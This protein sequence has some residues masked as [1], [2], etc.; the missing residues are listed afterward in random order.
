MEVAEN[1]YTLYFQDTRGLE[2]ENWATSVHLCPPA[3]LCGCQFHCCLLHNKPNET[4]QADHRLLVHG[5]SQRGSPFQPE[6]AVLGG[7]DL[8]DQPPQDSLV[9]LAILLLP[10]ELSLIGRLGGVDAAGHQHLLGHVGFRAAFVVDPIRELP[11]VGRIVLVALCSKV[12]VQLSALLDEGSWAVLSHLGFG[13][14]AAAGQ[15]LPV[16]L[17]PMLYAP[18][19]NRGEVAS[20]QQAEDGQPPCTQTVLHGGRI[21]K[22]KAELSLSLLRCPPALQQVTDFKGILIS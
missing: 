9:E 19:L 10:G 6:I 5:D 12:D 22:G 20:K 17:E 7:T 3:H 1:R 2:S 16:P 11:V 18:G 13:N 15:D 4:Q 8:F 14:L 21:C